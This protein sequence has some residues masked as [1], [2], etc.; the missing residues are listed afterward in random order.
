M[1]SSS[2]PV[3]EFFDWQPLQV[4]AIELS[5]GQIDRAIQLSQSAATDPNQQWQRY[6]DAL[7]LLGF[8]EWLGDRAPDLPFQSN[9]CTLLQPSPSIPQQGVWNLQ[10]G[11]FSVALLSIGSLM[12][13]VVQVPA[14]DMTGRSGSS[15]TATAPQFYVLIEVLEEQELVR[16]YG[17]LRA[18]E[19]SSQIARLTPDAEGSYEVP[20]DW[21]TPDPDRL[22]LLL[23]ALE[24]DATRTVAVAPAL[25]SEPPPRPAARA[26][27]AAA[28]PR[29][30]NAARWLRSQLDAIADDVSN[31]LDAIADDLSWV[32]LSPAPAT[33]M[34]WRHQELQDI[35]TALQNRGL[36]VPAS[37]GGAYSDLSPQDIPLRLHTLI[38]TL[39]ETAEWVLLVVLGPQ[40]GTLLP[41]GI[42][43][44]VRDNQQVLADE[45][46]TP[47]NQD[48]YLYA[49]VI[50]T[51][52]ESFGITIDLPDGSHVNLPLLTFSDEG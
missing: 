26:S 16:V 18:N 15:T 46:L 28:M 19:L 41:S 29:V 27:L 25:A 40:P 23:R 30:I 9:R 11:A 42:R 45:A 36:Q 49:L 34:R 13:S 8:Q 4:D 38:W 48:G 52:G 51:V 1:L 10:V 7:A 2:L 3:P 32:M 37:A 17:Y 44:R 47:A 22:L 50:G 6:L 24:A 21:F 39:P 31:Q 35:T 5:P 20:L 43:L 14:A 12:D 33:A